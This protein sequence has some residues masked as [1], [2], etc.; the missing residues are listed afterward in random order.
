MYLLISCISFCIF[1]TIYR[2]RY[3]IILCI[4]SVRCIII[5]CTAS[6]KHLLRCIASNIMYIVSNIMYIVSNIMYFNIIICAASIKHLLRYIVISVRCIV[7]IVRYI[8]IS[9]RR[10]VLN[11]LLNI[12]L[13]FT[14]KTRKKDGFYK[15]MEILFNKGRIYAAEEKQTSQTY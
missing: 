11:L 3:T 12:N 2:Y 15:K 9:V 1:Y 10:V 7:S 5:L 4:A 14:M 13:F 8:M 6:I